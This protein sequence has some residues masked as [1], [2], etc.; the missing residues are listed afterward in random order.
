VAASTTIWRLK[1]S[2]NSKSIPTSLDSAENRKEIT[3]PQKTSSPKNA[4]GL[5][6][7]NNNSS[8]L[9]QTRGAA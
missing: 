6:W 3:A 8:T 5:V 7:Y 1:M 2:V 9:Q 4:Q